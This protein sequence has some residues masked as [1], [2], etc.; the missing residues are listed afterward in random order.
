MAFLH[1]F[2][3]LESAIFLRM[4]PLFAPDMSPEEQSAMQQCLESGW[5]S[6]AAPQVAEFE[7]ALADYTGL[8]ERSLPLLTLLNVIKIIICDAMFDEFF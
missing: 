2:E 3:H 6:S 1:R 8:D 4:I 5:I 7:R